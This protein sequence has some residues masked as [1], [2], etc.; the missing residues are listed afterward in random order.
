MKPSDWFYDEV[1]YA[2][3]AGYISGY[4][5]GTFKP[6]NAITRQEA[7]VVIAKLLGLT[8]ES[9]IAVEPFSDYISIDQW[10]MSSVDAVAAHGIMHGFPDKTFG[11]RKNITRAET[12]VILDRALAYQGDEDEDEIIDEID[13]FLGIKGTVKINNQPVRGATVR[14][15]VKDS[16]EVLKDTVTGEDGSF[17]FEVPEGEYELTAVRE[18]YVGYTGI[19]VTKAGAADDQEISLAEGA[20]V[21]GTILDNR[22]NRLKNIPFAFTVNP[23]FVGNTDNNGAFSIVLPVMDNNGQTL[24]YTGYVLYNGSWEVFAANQQFSGDTNLG[25][26]RA[27]ISTRS[28]GGGG[29]GGSSDTTAPSWVDGYPKAENVT[30]DGFRLFFKADEDCTA[31]YVVLGKDAAAPGSA[32][33]KSGADGQKDLKANIE[34]SVDVS[35]LAANTTYNI[36]VVAEDAAGNLQVSPVNVVVR[37]DDAPGDTTAPSWVDGYPK[38]ENVTHDGFRLF[39]KA[40][41]DC[42][43]YYVV[44]GKDAAAPGSADVKSGADGQKDLK[45]NIEESV[46]VSGLVAN[47]TYNIYVVA[48]DNA[49]NLQDEPKG[50]RVSTENAPAL[51]LQYAAVDGANLSL[52]FNKRLD[53]ASLP[54][55]D[56]FGINVNGSGPAALLSATIAGNRVTLALAQAVIAGDTVTVSYTPGTSPLKDEDGNSANAF[57]GFSVDNH[58]G[59]LAAPANDPTVATPMLDSTAF[60]YS[61]D[62]AVQAGVDAGKIEEKRVAVLRGRVLTRDNKPLP[63]VKIT[64]LN[65]PEFGST[66]SRKDGCYDMVV[67]GGGV[68]TV[69]YEKEG[70]LDAQRQVDVP[71]QD[72]THLP[73]VVLVPYDSKAT[74]VTPGDNSPMQVVRGST[75]SDKDGTRTATL[76][77]PAG[78]Q[79]ETVLPDGSRE[80]LDSL[81]VRATEYT[82]GENGPQAMPAELPPNV[83]YTYCVDY[84]ADEAEHVIFSQPIIHYVENFIGAPV[85]GIVPMG[86]Y[87]YE[88]A[89]WVPSENGLVIKILSIT[90]GLAD[91]DLDGSG[92]AADAAALAALNITAEE[93]QKLAA[94]YQVGQELWRVPITHFTPWDCNWPYGPPLDADRPNLPPPRS[95]NE[96]NPCTGSGSI[97]EFQT[98]VLG[99]SAKVY[100]TPFSLNYRSSRVEGNKNIRSL[101]IPISTA[102]DLHPQLKR[103]EL[104]V[105]VAGQLFT[106]TFAPEK[107]QE[108]I[109]TWDGK[110]AYGRS[111]QGTVPYEVRIGYV[112]PAIYGNPAPLDRSFGSYG[113]RSPE[114]WSSDMDRVEGTIWVT[115]KGFFSYWDATKAGLGGWSLNIH[116]AYDPESQVLYYGDGSERSITPYGGFIMS[117]VA[118]TGTFGYSGDG[119]PATEA[120]LCEPGKIAIGPDGSIYIAETMGHRIRRVS[121]DGIITTVA[122]NG[123]SGFSGDGGPATEAK[124]NEPWGMDIGPDGALYFADHYN[125]RI[126]RVDPEDGTITTVAGTGLP[127]YPSG[128]FYSGEGDL[129]TEAPIYRP[130]DVAVSS[131]GSIYIADSSHRVFRV[132]PDGRINVIAGKLSGPNAISGGYS[133]DGGPASE[134]R[135]NYPRSIDLGPDGSLY[136]A[137]TFNYRVRRVD[138]SGIITTVAGTGGDGFS[139]DGGPAID[140]QVAPISVEVSSDGSLFIADGSMRIR[141]VGPDGIITTAAGNGVYGFRGDGGLA[142]QAEIVPND[143][144]VAPDGNFYI[145]S[146]DLYE[147][148]YNRVRRAGSLLPGF[149]FGEFIIP[150]EDGSALFVFDSSGRHLRTINALTGST[151]YTFTYDPQGRLTEV[152]DAFDN[153]TRIERDEQDKL[154]AIVAPGGQTTWLE[155]GANG[156]LAKIICPLFKETSLEYSSEGLLTSLSDHKE[157]VHRF[158]YDEYG[159]LVRDEDPA[160]GYTELTRTELPDGYGYIVRVE[161]AEGRVSTYEVN[162]LGTDVRRVNTDASGAET[163]ILINNDGTRQVTYTDGTIITMEVGPDPR[164]GIGMG[165]PVT[166]E[167]TIV[168]PEG[169]TSKVTRERTAEMTDPNDLFSVTK[170]TDVVTI[171]GNKYNS[172]YDIDRINQTITLNTSTPEGRQTQTIF[173][174][175]GR[176]LEETADGLEPVNYRYDEKGHLTRVEQGDQ[177]LTYT[178]DD[179]NRVTELKDAAGNEFHYTYNGADLLTGITMPGGQTYEFSYDAN[180]NLTAITMPEGATQGATHQ[181]G[182]TTVDLGESYTPP[183][184]ASYQK[185]YDRDRAVTRLTLPGGRTVDYEYDDGGRVTGMAYDSVQSTFGYNDL[186]DRVAGIERNPDGINYSF[187]YDGSLPTQMTVSVSGE[188]YGEYSYSYDNNFKLIGFTAVGEPGVLLGYDKDGLLTKYGDF[189]IEHN[190]PLGAPSQISDG[191]MTATYEYDNLGRPEKRTSTVNGNPVYSLELTYD[192]TGMIRTKK[193]TVASAVYEYEYAYDANKQ[194]TGVERG[195]AVVETYTY[196]DNG[197]RLTATYDDNGNRLTVEADYDSQDRL[198]RLGDVAYQFNDDGFLT[199]RGGDVFE[200]TA[201]G[202]LYRATLQDGLEVTYAYDGLGRRVGRSVVASTYEAPV[203]EYYLY[204]N[205]DYPFQVTAVRDNTGAV[206]QYYYDE[207]NFLYAIKQGADWYYVATDHQGTPRVVTDAGGQVVKVMEYDSYGNLTYDSNPAFKLA[208]GYAGGIA[209]PD[210]GLVHFGLRDYDPAAGRWTARDPILFN[211]QQGN[212]YVYVNNNPVNL[213][214][215]FGLF[216]IGGTLYGGIG[217]G[218]QLCITGEGVSICA[219]VGFGVGAGVEVAPFGGLARTGSTVG[220]QGGLSFA[221]IGPSAGLTL[222]DCGTLKF[223]GGVNVGP[224]SQSASYD[225][226]E[227]KWGLDD[228]TVGGDPGDLLKNVTEAFNPKFG[229]SF[230]V[231]GQKCLRL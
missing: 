135:L 99:E 201:M 219:E 210:T 175:Y 165:A 97:I 44:L 167:F 149:R 54:Q 208:I 197:N 128:E 33:V 205:P 209:D 57:A 85:G 115:W 119:G 113:G 174:R 156:L 162:Y 8:P 137:D 59:I 40:D 22:G 138:T 7:A 212:L 146:S 65:H 70:Y 204:G 55:V 164:P 114:G 74:T 95:N 63:D 163:T 51:S 220:V 155:V 148:G 18:K 86:Y 147:E 231:F 141:R 102:E 132:G 184:N 214:D 130:M 2:K 60:L 224:F 177:S 153:V 136:I 38:A 122:G 170:I 9:G 104:E 151:I 143:V 189:T 20:K 126:R 27:N 199:Q 32:D 159:R 172:T 43:A 68:L 41:E 83:G 4:P 221:G 108:Y 31:Y 173:D 123:T 87:D 6:Y 190:G 187:E 152:R 218:G 100:G 181:L 34:E 193:E 69:R 92:S 145:S 48:E 16:R 79:A 178:Y 161:T 5:D 58:T 88:Q 191:R 12:V 10:A 217:G 17:I 169:L 129:A 120:E 216:C 50:L 35:G 52:T 166:R 11:P 229:A 121:P 53:P 203:S 109:F 90:D 192:N 215:P 49:G 76:I 227:G 80:S 223:T 226:T 117:T 139:G 42:T 36:Y 24:S 142:K 73:D 157:N 101:R 46:D 134:A 56:D 45:A 206:S 13:E 72:F 116:H 61:G 171:N 71:W 127:G 94:L 160:G 89:A 131:D 211:G 110:D 23:S 3:A 25:Q 198:T 19:T 96:E 194:L 176:T 179:M 62:N 82:V 77:I 182:Y 67:N 185:S 168:T 66:Q 98:Q 111:I 21:S 133:G 202:E 144:A 158:T 188:V 39:F 118:G 47:T 154:K 81:T 29:D 1:A 150:A 124:L 26:L 186:T 106:K 28:S 230:K 37:T 200:Y 84:S 107:N 93:R 213:R 222:D 105:S 140:A 196:D 112:Y 91:L 207:S 225:F 228:F 183:D 78:V 180:G 30:H 103:I 125:N 14:I 15:F 75:V 195:G 64:V